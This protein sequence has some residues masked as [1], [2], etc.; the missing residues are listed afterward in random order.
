MTRSMVNPTD[1]CKFNF[2]DFSTKSQRK[3]LSKDGE[4]WS[5]EQNLSKKEF[6][7]IHFTLH[8]LIIYLSLEV[9]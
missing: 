4:I 8:V 5:F 9:N 2:D 1:G 7:H 3:K 6:Y